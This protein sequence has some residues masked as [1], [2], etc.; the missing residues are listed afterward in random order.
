MSFD[1]VDDVAARLGTPW[2]GIWRVVGRPVLWLVR[3]GPKRLDVSLV[4]LWFLETYRVMH[5]VSS[6]NDSL[7]GLVQFGGG[8]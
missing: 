8:P 5:L 6:C 2:W 3:L 7:N 4:W 1:T